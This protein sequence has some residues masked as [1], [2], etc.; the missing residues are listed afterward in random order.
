MVD[1]IPDD[2]TTDVS[3]EIGDI[4]NSDLDTDSDV[5]WIRIDLIEGQEI[6]IEMTGITLVDPYLTLFD[7][8]GNSVAIDDDGGPGRNSSLYF[9]APEDGTYYIEAGSWYR[10]FDGGQDTG[11]YTLSVI[12]NT[13]PYSAPHETAPDLPAPLSAINW[14]TQLSDPEVT[15]FFAPSGYAA[16]GITSEGFNAYERAQFQAAFDMISA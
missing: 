9:T 11:T 12:E 10:T 2:I 5:D 14:G 1:T 15:V 3:I 4:I 8:E 16:D 7:S 6:Q 13:P